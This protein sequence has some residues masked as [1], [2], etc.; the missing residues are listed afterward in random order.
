MARRPGGR[1]RAGAADR[2]R[3]RAERARR[4]RD[5]GPRRGAR[6]VAE[7]PRPDPRRERPGARPAHDRARTTCRT[8]PRELAVGARVAPG[9]AARASCSTSATRRSLEVAGRG[10]FARRGGIVDVFPP[11]APLPVRIEFFGDEIDSLRALRPDRPA[12]GRRAR[13]RSCCCP[14]RSSSLP[15]GGAA[16]LRERLGRRGRASSPSG[17][18]RTSSGSSGDDAARRAQAAGARRRRRGRGLGAAARAGD[19]PRPP[20]RRDTLLVLDEPGDIAEAAEFLWRQADERR[21]ELSRPASCRRT[22]RRPTS[23]RATGSAGS[24]RARTLELT[25]ESEAPRRRRSPARGLSSGDLFGWREPQLPPGRAAAIARGGRALAA[26]T[27]PGSSSPPTRRRASPSSS[28]R[29][30]IAAGVVRRHR[31]APPPGASRSSSAA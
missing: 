2:P 10:E 13:A 21:A 16:A 29:P 23:G 27:A 18:P 31:D 7:R 12:D 22:G 20:R 4:R 15:H 26:R 17:S 14:R 6:G 3:L 5:G 25:W 19:R 1:R 9:R 24:S 30:A 28:R 11:S 8:Q